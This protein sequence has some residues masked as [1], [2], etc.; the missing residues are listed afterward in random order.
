MTINNHYLEDLFGSTPETRLLDFMIASDGMTVYN[1][2]EL[3]R[4]ID[5]S[6][7][8]TSNAAEK[9]AERNMLNIIKEATKEKRYIRYTKYCL[10]HNSSIVKNIIV[11]KDTLKEATN[12]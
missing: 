1:A 7:Q 11:L 6:V 10:N 4:E 8:R 5:V 9:L 12:R 3:A 2:L